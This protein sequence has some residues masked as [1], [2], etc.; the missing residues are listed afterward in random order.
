MLKIGI[1]LTLDIPKMDYGSY[2]VYVEVQK[3]D[4]GHNQKKRIVVYEKWNSIVKEVTPFDEETTLSDLVTAKD[5][6]I[7]PKFLKH[8]RNTNRKIKQ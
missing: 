5:K 1:Y 7:R 6:T 8:V 3:S 4:N 2:I